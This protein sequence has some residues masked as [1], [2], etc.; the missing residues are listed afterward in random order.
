MQSTANKMK[1]TI[2]VSEETRA[3]IER[4]MNALPKQGVDLHD[5][6]GVPRTAVLISWL[7]EQEDNR[8]AEKGSSDASN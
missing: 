7:I 3:R 5:H 2:Y 4:L 1:M 8:Q 6:T